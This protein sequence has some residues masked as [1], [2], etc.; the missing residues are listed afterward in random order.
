MT[1]TGF[2]WHER[3]AW[4]DIGAG[5]GPLRAG[6]WVEPGEQHAEHA[7]TKRRI[8]NLIDASGLLDELVQ[9]KP[10]AAT[11]AQL[12]RFHT[13][14][15]VA[16]ARELSEGEG[17]SIGFDAFVGRG[18]EPIARLAAGG[19]IAAVDAVMTGRVTNA[20][21]LIR[22]CGHHA[23]AAE[24]KGFCI[25]N[26]GVLA[27]LHA[28]AEHGAERIAIVD[29]DVHHGNGAQEA[30][31]EDP[32]TLTISLHQEQVF[33]PDSGALEERGA[34]AGHG[35]N[36]NLPLPPGCGI[37]AYEA[38]FERVVVP[39]LDAF[40]PDLLLIACGFDAGAHDPMGR[41]QLNPGAFRTMTRMAMEVA[42]RHCGGRLAMTHEGGYHTGL[43]PFCGLAVMEQLSGLRT[44]VEDPWE[45][46]I[47]SMGWQALQPH[48]EAAIEA[49]AAY[50]EDVPRPSA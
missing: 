16:R 47:G 39:A 15:H 28:R 19:A 14:E 20:Y 11:D 10:A 12:E 29:W 46:P 2:V 49:A 6:G 3:Y 33:P 9:I 17:G 44:E 36:L 32:Q 31:W 50:V 5:T 26:N 48:Q 45:G 1:T 13:P 27:A 35:A 43:A 23:V 8:R 7:A 40:A 30:F 21:A 37:G 18:S 25:Y 22:P 41:Q 4:H 34:G 38:A 42:E 24:G